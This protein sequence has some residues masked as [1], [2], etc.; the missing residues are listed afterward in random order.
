LGFKGGQGGVSGEEIGNF[1]AGGLRGGWGGVGWADV[2]KGVGLKGGPD[3]GSVGGRKTRAGG[4]KKETLVLGCQ[5]TFP[6]E[7]KRKIQEL[8]GKTART[9]RNG[10]T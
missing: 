9:V 6:R 2:A 1:G 3:K 4:K 7:K 8:M 10:K 5:R